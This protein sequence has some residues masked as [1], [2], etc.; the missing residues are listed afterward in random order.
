MLPSAAVGSCAGPEINK[1]K[2]R[3][4]GLMKERKLKNGEKGLGTSYK[5][6]KRC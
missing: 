5:T 3:N 6:H 2:I 1:M 4:N